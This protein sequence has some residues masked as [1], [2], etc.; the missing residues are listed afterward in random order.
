MNPEQEEDDVSFNHFATFG[1]IIHAFARLEWVIQGTMAAVSDLDV[2]KIT[3]LT[4]ELGYTAKRDALYSYMELYDTEVELKTAIK[5][6]LDGANEHNGLRNHIAHSLWKKGSR[7]NSIR[8][9]TIRVRSGK[10]KLIGE[11]SDP[12]Y[13]EVDLAHIADKL[14][15]I[16]N[17]YMR[18]MES[19][20]FADFMQ[21]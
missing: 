11:D 20:G 9:L 17:S 14:R 19:K 16:H 18:F 21:E 4:R 10:G 3:T 5:G 13:T 8:P 15:Q 7:P 6:F 1:G 2:G 12:N